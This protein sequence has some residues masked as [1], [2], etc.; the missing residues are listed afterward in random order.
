[1]ELHLRPY[2][3]KDTKAILDI[4]NYNILN[5]TSLYDYKIRTI[6]QQQQIIEEKLEKNFPVIV[7]EIKGIVIGF[8][9]YSEFRFREAYKFTVEHSVYIDHNHH[10]NGFGKIILKELISIA[11]KKGLHTMIGVIDANNTS[12]IKFHENLGFKKVGEIKEA[13]YKFDKWLDTIFMQ[14]II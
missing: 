11:K 6:E 13:A 5:S 4:I 8:G 7:A 10:G 14:L 2:Q 9:M 3:Q 12:S 1:M